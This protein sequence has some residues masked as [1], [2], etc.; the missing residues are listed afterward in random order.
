MSWDCKGPDG[1]RYFY[2][3]RRLDGRFIQEYV[4]TGPSTELTAPI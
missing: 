2:R 3:S 4:G 1:P